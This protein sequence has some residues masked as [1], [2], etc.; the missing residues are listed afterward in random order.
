MRCLGWLD[1]DSDAHVV[2]PVSDDQKG[3][4][5]R[6]R[7]P[8][9]ALSIESQDDEIGD[10]TTGVVTCS[11]A[12]C[13][14]RRRRSSTAAS[15]RCASPRATTARA[16]F[17]A[18]IAVEHLGTVSDTRDNG[19]SR[20]QAQPREARSIEVAMTTHAGLEDHQPGAPQMAE[21]AVDAVLAVADVERRDVNLDL[22]KMDGK[23]GGRSRTRGSSRAS[24]STRTCR[25]RRWPRRSRTRSSACSVAQPPFEPPKPKTK[26]KLELE[27]VQAY[28]EMQKA[29]SEYFIDMIEKVKASGANL[30]ICQW[31]FDDEANHLLM[32]E[33]AARRPLGRR[34][35]ARAHRDRVQR[36]HRA[37]LLRALGREARHRGRARGV[38][39]HD[40]GP[41]DRDRGLPELEGGHGLRA[42]RQQDDH[43]R[44]E[45][46]AARRHLRRAQPGPQQA[47]S[48]AAARPSSRA[49]S[50][51][52]R[53]ADKCRHDR[54]VRRPLRAF[55]EALE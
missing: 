11:R 9:V 25:T 20:R 6:A 52:S 28:E 10:G 18:A 50:R 21:I 46:L 44:G 4:A 19:R 38:L 34:R 33:R 45:A 8:L 30:V 17:T 37:A 51:S 3:R 14:R 36:A 26:H 55:A 40:Q 5:R 39:R 2:G 22:I 23:V 7:A 42:R 48:T 29:E 32:Q 27:T 24:W 53:R 15:T 49:R 12:R 16:I 41:D 54:A 13:S 47:S 43:R 35:R 31:G 1:R